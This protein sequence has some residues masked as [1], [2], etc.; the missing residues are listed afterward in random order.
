MRVLLVEDDLDFQRSL[1]DLLVRAGYLVDAVGDG[2]AALEKVPG[3]DVLVT[4]IGVPGMDGLELLSR[5][6]AGNPRVS[7]IVMTGY[8][9]PRRRSEAQRRG[10][11]TYLVKPF[12]G[13]ELLGCLR[14][15]EAACRPR[16]AKPR[17][18]SRGQV[19]G[20]E[21]LVSAAAAASRANSGRIP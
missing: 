10:A 12:A 3:A 5:A 2:R 19:E 9:S 7:V 21:S 15:L 17:A 14:T 8:D 11:C 13:L 1:E 6:R 20:R 4:D 18:T 16:L